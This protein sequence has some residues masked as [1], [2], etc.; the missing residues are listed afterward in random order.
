[1][2]LRER[3]VVVRGILEDPTVAASTLSNRVSSAQAGS[4]EMRQLLTLSVPSAALP[5][6]GS[7]SDSYTVCT[8][9]T[10]YYVLPMPYAFVL[11]SIRT[12]FNLLIH[13]LLYPL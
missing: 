13:F 6:K 9:F 8:V 1:M 4:V 7:A 3:D 11:Q 2:S 5:L 10:V 12:H